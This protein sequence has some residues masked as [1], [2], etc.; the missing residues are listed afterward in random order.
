VLE[1]A[2]AAG[3]PVEEG[4]LPAALLGGADEI[5]LTN[6]SWEVLPVTRV[7]GLPA[8]G[9]RPGPLSGRLLAGYRE[10]VRRECA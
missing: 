3:I 4:P 1:A 10:Q 9:G 5:F 2:H 7:D 8:G 6:T